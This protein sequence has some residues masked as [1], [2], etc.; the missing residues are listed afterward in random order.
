M[1]SLF[2]RDMAL[3]V[4]INAMRSEQEAGRNERLERLRRHRTSRSGRVGGSPG[5][6]AGGKAALKTKG[7][8]MH[9]S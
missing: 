8:E 1:S 5:S 4:R 2:P 9:G 3:L 6:I 7:G